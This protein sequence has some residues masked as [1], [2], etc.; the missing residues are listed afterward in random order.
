VSDFDWKNPDYDAIFKARSEALIRIRE[1]PESIPQLKAY[2][3]EHP[4]DFINDWG[5]TYDPRNADIGLPTIIPFILFPRQR[6]WIDW[7]IDRWKSRKPGLCEKSR[8]MG[9]SW[10]AM[11][12]S[13]TLCLFY[14]GLAIGVGSRKVE[15][16]DQL[17]MSKPLLPKARIFMRHLP[18][19]FRGGWDDSC[20]PY[21]RFYFPETKST[22][23]GEGGN[24]LGRGDR[25]AV[26]FV[27][28]YA[29]FERP[30]RTEASLSQTT[31]CRIDMSSVNG[32]ANSF[33]VK[34]W[35]GKVDVFRFHWRDDPRKG[36]AWYAAQL[37]NLDPIIVAQE[38][39]CD[40]SASVEGI[41]I[42]GAWVRAC[43]DACEKLG[44]T[45][46]GAKR[47][48]LDVADEGKDKNAFCGAH[49]VQIELIEEWSGKGSDLYDTAQR[50][51]GLC[52]EYGYLGFRYDADGPGAG[53]RG[54]MRVINEGR[55]SVRANIHPVEG[56][57]GSGQVHDP[58]GV[59]EGTTGLDGG[60]LGRKNKDYFGNPKAQG[61]F[62]LRRRAQKTFRWVTKGIAC[63]PDEI[64]SISSKC[65][66]YMK[67]VAQLSQPTYKTNDAGKIIVDKKPQGMP[68]P[69][70][71]D[72]AMMVFAPGGGAAAVLV[73]QDLINRVRVLPRT[74]QY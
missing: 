5:I 37:E 15:Y 41:V 19:E 6:E 26:Y 47:A 22:I 45:P 33:A 40:Y 32:M 50:A 13:C 66:N 39:D 18:P 46:T 48:A 1:H 68:S 28:E 24:D 44:I 58:E 11:G 57:R 21:M 59:V 53:I 74:R 71:A 8:D 64:L 20:A 7:V 38:I 63:D 25:T 36:D 72:A 30:E 35:S 4:A 52:D 31:N 51:V 34:R 27:D 16:V 2:Y 65:P 49:G 67:L 17:D 10:L 9:V 54:D 23:G 60:D 62:A 12:L 3:R 69:D 29:H 56:W 61:W 73:T 43:I 55:R 70:L 42:P 14:D